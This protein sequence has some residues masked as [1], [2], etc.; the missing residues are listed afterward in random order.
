MI[1]AAVGYGPEGDVGDLND[2]NIRPEPFHP[3]SI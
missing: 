2:G 3:T 1:V